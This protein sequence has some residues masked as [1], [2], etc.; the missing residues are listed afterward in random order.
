[1]AALVRAAA[2]RWNESSE[3]TVAADD[4]DRPLYAW[5][6]SGGLQQVLGHLV[7]N[8][9]KYSP[10]GEPVSIRVATAGPWVSVDV[11]DRGVGIP[12]DVNVFAPFQ[13]A[14]PAS[15]ATTGVGLGLHIARRVVEAMGGSLSVRRNSHGGSTFAVRVRREPPAL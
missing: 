3:T 14:D 7:D 5:A 6:D 1:V 8:A 10:G 4:S 2:S 9:I 13:Q 12:N 11:V 15:D